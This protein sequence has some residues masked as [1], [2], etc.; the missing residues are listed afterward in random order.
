M[1]FKEYYK[2][3][4]TFDDLVKRSEIILKQKAETEKEY[5]MSVTKIKKSNISKRIK[6]QHNYLKDETVKNTVYMAIEILEKILKIPKT[7][8]YMLSIAKG[9]GMEGEGQVM[10]RRGFEIKLKADIFTAVN[11]GIN[12]LKNLAHEMIHVEQY[13]SGKM[14]QWLKKQSNKDTP[15]LKRMWEIDAFKR[16]DS[17]HK[18]L[19]LKSDG[20]FLDSNMKIENGKIYMRK[21]KDSGIQWTKELMVALGKEIPGLTMGDLDEL[22]TEIEWVEVYI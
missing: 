15:Y 21:V 13:V 19:L 7:T 20:L 12:L 18:K 2:E 6:F 22:E 3:D 8:K 9:A 5:E 11:K 10:Y 17:I 4:A 16:Q 14:E 1:R